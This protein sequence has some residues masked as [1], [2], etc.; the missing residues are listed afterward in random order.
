MY[1]R[2]CFQ[3]QLGRLLH[4]L[5]QLLLQLLLLFLLHVQQKHGVCCGVVGVLCL[6]CFVQY[7]VRPR[8]RTVCE[9][10]EKDERLQQ[11]YGGAGCPGLFPTWDE[12]GILEEVDECLN[13]PPPDMEVRKSII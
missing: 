5:L 4:Y 8:F 13:Q 7:R 2:F 9:L 11:K 10:L 3:R 12:G 6:V 1:R